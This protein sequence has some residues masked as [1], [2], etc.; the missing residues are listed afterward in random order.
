[1]ACTS[2]QLMRNV[3]RPGVY[4]I[5]NGRPLLRQSNIVQRTAVGCPAGERNM[6]S[7][8]APPPP[9]LAKY[10][11]RHTV[12]MLPGHGIGPEMM[13]YVK[14]VFR[15]AGIP[16]DFEEINMDATSDN[17]DEVH[18]AI[19]SI[20]RNGVALK[21]NIETR[22]NRPNFKSRN[23]EL[24]NNLDLYV[25]VLHCKSY[26]GLAT[27]H[28]DVDIVIIRQNTEGEYSMMEHEN[29][30]GVVECLKIITKR[31]SERIAK[32]AFE[33]AKEHGRK[34]VTAIHKAN[35][36]KV[37]DGLFIECCKRVSAQYPDI[38]FDSMIIDNCCMQLVSYPQQFDV[39]VMPNLYGSI[40][41]N[42]VCGLSGGAGLFSGGNYGEKYAIFEPGTRNTGSS[43][44]GKNIANPIAMLNAGV[45]LLDHLQLD[46]HAKFMREA[47]S[48]TVNEDKIHTPDLG[49]QATSTD[50]VQNVIKLIQSSTQK[51]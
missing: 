6:A 21:G 38:K 22:V 46:Y 25:S 20:K 26:A 45:D 35:I 43:I 9:P 2:S 10:G 39:M 16:V 27:R 33:Y 5:F 49:G 42:V 47:I 12:T 34:K 4:N 32:F 36:M 3:I 28:K 14:E 41:S 7:S 50:V 18:Y 51:W 40:V 13:G 44:A 30:S 11:G 23:V 15:Y 37:S 17:L 19:T 8:A 29:V 31:N 48:K 24:R 1:M